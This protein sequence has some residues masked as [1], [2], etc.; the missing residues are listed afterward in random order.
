MINAEES[1]KVPDYIDIVF[2]VHYE[3]FE[4][5]G[6]PVSNFFK[7]EDLKFNI[8]A[9][10]NGDNPVGSVVKGKDI[11]EYLNPKFFTIRPEDINS[12]RDVMH[13]TL[14]TVFSDI[15]VSIFSNIVQYRNSIFHFYIIS[16]YE[17]YF[18]VVDGVNLNYYIEPDI[19]PPKT[20]SKN[21]Q[22]ASL[23]FREL[24]VPEG[25]LGGISL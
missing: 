6:S 3:D 1:E 19:D 17:D 24:P 21:I 23:T 4:S 8:L 7:E 2:K 20:H 15:E 5:S 25:P 9:T 18:K 13:P 14:A 11:S 10:Y 12:G 22:E 16:D